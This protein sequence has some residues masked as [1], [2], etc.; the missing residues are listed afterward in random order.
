MNKG[1]SPYAIRQKIR[2]IVHNYNINLNKNATP[3]RYFL[4]FSHLAVFTY[5]PRLFLCNMTKVARERRY[6]RKR[7]PPKNGRPP[8]VQA[9]VSLLIRVP[10][11]RRDRLWRGS[12]R[13]SYAGQARRRRC[14]LTLP[15]SRLSLQIPRC[16]AR[17]NPERRLLQCSSLR[18][19]C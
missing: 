18:R 4:K 6:P 9:E 3:F 15:S 2:T 1:K 13:R 10:M 17:S 7:E 12:L 5:H 19:G 11:W 16:L 8:Q 14:F